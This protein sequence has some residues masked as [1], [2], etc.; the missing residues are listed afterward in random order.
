[1]CNLTIIFIV[2]LQIYSKL[3]YLIIPSKVNIT[4]IQ[5]AARKVGTPLLGVWDRR[6]SHG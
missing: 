6:A 4:P 5:M 2:I 3:S 1:M